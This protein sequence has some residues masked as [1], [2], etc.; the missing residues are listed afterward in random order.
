MAKESRMND[1]PDWVEKLRV[2]LLNRLTAQLEGTLLLRFASIGDVTPLILSQLKFRE[3]SPS[4]LKSRFKECPIG[5]ETGEHLI[6]EMVNEICGCVASASYLQDCERIARYMSA[7]TEDDVREVIRGEY[8][9][10]MEGFAKAGLLVRLYGGDW[11][12]ARKGLEE[13]YGSLTERVFS[14]KTFE[15]LLATYSPCKGKRFRS[16]LMKNITWRCAD[17]VKPTRRNAAPIEVSID[18]LPSDVGDLVLAEQALVRKPW[19]SSLVKVEEM[20]KKAAAMRFCQDRLK[21]QSTKDM[22]EL[23]KQQIAAIQLRLKAFINPYDMAPETLLLV[24]NNS[25]PARIERFWEEYYDCVQSADELYADKNQA[26][27]RLWRAHRE[28]DERRE[29][30]TGLGCSEDELGQLERHTLE[31]GLEATY[32]ASVAG[33]GGQPIDPELVEGYMESYGKYREAKKKAE[34]L[35]CQWGAYRNGHV[36]WARSEIEIGELI[37]LSQSTIERRLKSAKQF[38]SQCLERRLRV[39]E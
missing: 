18:A 1:L 3:L 8:R 27:D 2:Y 19:P 32:E 15:R 31:D 11:N 35:E 28:W 5:D 38:L 24:K 37:G 39:R 6:A 20:K 30:L 22:P 23:G 33:S 7:D 12:Q 9:K 17:V 16:F 25:G 36:P 4:S 14:P 34:E 13:A 21:K 10:E 29:T 26:K